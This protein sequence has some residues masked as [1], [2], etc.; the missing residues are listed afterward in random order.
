M[1][2]TGT[3]TNNVMKSSKTSVLFAQVN[4]IA[5]FK[6]ETKVNPKEFTP[7]EFA[8]FEKF[9]KEQADERERNL[10]Q[11][12]KASGR[13]TAPVSHASMSDEKLQHIR[14]IKRV[15][16]LRI[17]YRKRYPEKPKEEIEVMVQKYIDDHPR[18]SDGKMKSGPPRGSTMKRKVKEITP[19]SLD[20]DQ[21]VDEDTPRPKGKHSGVNY[22]ELFLKDNPDI[23]KV[24]TPGEF[25]V[26]VLRRYQR[27]RTNYN[28]RIRYHENVEAM[29]QKRREQRQVEPERFRAIEARY[30]ERASTNGS[31][32][33]K[34]Y[35]PPKYASNEEW[36]NSVEYRWQCVVWS[37]KPK[38]LE[39]ELNLSD[40]ERMS[41]LLCYYCGQDPKEIGTR[42]GIDRVD[43]T[44][45]YTRANSVTCCSLCN[46]AKKDLHVSDFILAM[47]NVGHTFT[48]DDDK[49][50]TY[51]TS[52]MFKLPNANCRPVD[53]SAYRYGAG[54][55]GIEFDLTLE[56][57]D[58]LVNAACYYC[59]RSD[60][61]MGLDRFDNTSGYNDTS[62][63]ACCSMCNRLKGANDVD[64]FLCQAK[65]IYKLWY[66]RIDS[67]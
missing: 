16:Q 63:V 46:Y 52:Y 43:N 5:R 3:G 17:N 64:V 59:D 23:I 1:D 60:H 20:D 12:R 28:Y 18:T 55:R 56:Q 48:L 61:T 45:G 2:A 29:R 39:I 6:G 27:F 51:N 35:K 65:L 57:F 8:A 41:L 9:K 22:L 37:A 49:I 47:C 33:P 7:E 4:N 15:N 44:L 31:N 58:R 53:F 11:Q 13:L 19:E 62:C 67:V 50:T 24:E 42:F 26:D 36:L 34:E 38:Q 10:Y 30:R 66:D 14:D 32:H 21:N 25:P 54:R 40:I